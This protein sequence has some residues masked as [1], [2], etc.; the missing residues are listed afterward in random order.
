MYDFID[1]KDKASVLKQPSDD[2]LVNGRSLSE[3]VP[4]YR[5]L[6]VSGRGLVSRVVSTTDIPARRGTWV[7]NVR[8]DKLEVTI[9]YLLVAETPQ[10]LRDRFTKLNNALRSGED[11][12][13]TLT[14][15]D[16]QEYSYE[17]YLSSVDSLVEKHLT[18][19]SSFTLLIPDPY[20][21]G[22]IRNSSN[23]VINLSQASQ[24]LP[25]SISANVTKNT[26][27]LEIF[28]KQ[29]RM[30]FVGNYK[31]G[32]T[33]TVTWLDDEITCIYDARSILSE[34]AHLSVPEEF[35]LKDGDVVKGKNLTI[36]KVE[37]R[38]EKL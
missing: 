24:V 21:K 35:Y 20:R 28:T 18:V 1:I 12:R 31:A 14:F 11:G 16:D 2:L 26:T 29:Q 9:S 6:T 3:L 10:G 22:P 27:E 38:D 15:A 34:L 36:T 4:G 13:L 33:L 32:Q 8:D 5:Q 30:K 17:G 23:G 7:D 19:I 37:W 25:I